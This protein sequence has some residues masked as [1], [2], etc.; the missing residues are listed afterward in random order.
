VG[1]GAVIWLILAG[2]AAVTAAVVP[3]RIQYHRWRDRHHGEPWK[4]RTEQLATAIDT[5][6]GIG[7]KVRS[8]DDDLVTAPQIDHLDLPGDID[9]LKRL[10]EPGLSWDRELREI[11]EVL[12]YQVDH[13]WLTGIEDLP[14]FEYV[15]RL[16]HGG[17]RETGSVAEGYA[18]SYEWLR[19]LVY[20]G[21]EQ[22]MVHADLKQTVQ[23]ANEALAVRFQA[24]R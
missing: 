12:G 21:A 10:L 22:R 3:C 17:S 24:S 18:S 4:S 20:R 6:N 8:V 14:A 2:L 15:M 16:E 23:R 1:G 7:E 11:V 9:E 5:L 19:K 13:F